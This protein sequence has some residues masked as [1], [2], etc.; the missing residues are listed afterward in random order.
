[1]NPVH[2]IETV[3]GFVIPTAVVVWGVWMLWHWFGPGDIRQPPGLVAGVVRFL[4]VCLLVIFIILAWELF[5]AWRRP[6][7][8]TAR[9]GTPVS[10]RLVSDP[11]RL[12]AMSARSVVRINAGR[13]GETVSS[14]RTSGRRLEAWPGAAAG[15]SAATSGNR[16]AS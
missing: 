7:F 6:R 4:L 5:K 15:G 1:M 2:W 12:R 13:N 11:R 16:V 10:E 8:R 3:F 14:S 9:P